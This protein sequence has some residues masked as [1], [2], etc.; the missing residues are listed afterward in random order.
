[1]SLITDAGVPAYLRS[2]DCD[3]AEW[4]SDLVPS[5]LEAPMAIDEL[6][7]MS[8]QSDPELLQAE[9]DAQRKDIGSISGSSGITSKTY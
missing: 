5:S 2:L 7:V 6:I 1:M 8:A 9:A 4:P 3:R